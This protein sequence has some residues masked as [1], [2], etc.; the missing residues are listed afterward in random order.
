MLTNKKI[1]IC[2]LLIGTLA[3]ASGCT[4]K[5][6][7][8][9]KVNGM[10]KSQTADSS[11]NQENSKSQNESN[12]SNENYSKDTNKTNP[13]DEN[14]SINTNTQ[15]NSES[16]K[17]E[18]ELLNK[19]KNLAENGEII[20]CEF[21]A[22]ATNISEVEDKW[23]EADST[24]FVKDAKGTYSDYKEQGVAFGWNKGMQIFEA[25]T[26]DESLKS[27]SYEVVEEVFGK[28]EYTSTYDKDLIIGYKAGTDFKVLF[29]FSGGANDLGK[30]KLNHYSVLYPAGTVNS[31]AGDSGREW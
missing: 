12:T 22:K 3:M 27:I 21:K 17:V 29:V 24:E 19:I 26:F 15:N 8:H 20:N 9:E 18:K 4:N 25:R 6:T 7:I 23:G 28:P 1:F 30:A 5:V 11:K 14:S 16:L 2:L 31:M 13:S 10:E